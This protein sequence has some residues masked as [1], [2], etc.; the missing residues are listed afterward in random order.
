MVKWL[1]GLWVV[2]LHKRHDGQTMERTQH[3]SGYTP[4]VYAKC[5]PAFPWILS[6][7]LQIFGIHEG[8]VD[9][10]DYIKGG[11][12]VPHSQDVCMGATKV[13]I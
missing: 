7:P 6:M 1:C 3:P 4:T 13:P 11:H 2:V 9:S 10:R 8:T 12:R 5:E